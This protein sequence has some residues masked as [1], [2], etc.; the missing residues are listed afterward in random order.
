MQAGEQPACP[1]SL[2]PQQPSKQAAEPGRSQ[3]SSESQRL[4]RSGNL[5]L[6][7]QKEGESRQTVR[8]PALTHLSRSSPRWTL[9]RPLPGHIP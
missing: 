3:E 7:F 6:S 2:Y 9:Q 5:S 4:T 8:W 1:L